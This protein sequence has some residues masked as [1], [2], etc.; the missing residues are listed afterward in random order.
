LLGENYPPAKKQVLVDYLE[1]FPK[2]VELFVEFRHPGWF[3]NEKVTKEIF[4][5]MQKLK[6]GAI[7]T[8]TAGRR[9]CCHMHL[10]IPKAFIRFVGNSLHDTDYNRC[11]AWV[12]RI[13]YWLDRGLN[14]LYF[15]MHMHDEANS[16]ELT[17]YLVEKLNK[18][19]KLNLIKPQFV[20]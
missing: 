4:S 1:S 19:C 11:D 20:T 10:T 15:F 16:P 8:D 5:I 2:G 13:K 9:D 7:I 14:E 18:E 17:V 3:A 6:V 12:K